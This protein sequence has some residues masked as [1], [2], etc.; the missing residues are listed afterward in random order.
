[1]IFSAEEQK[2]LRKCWDCAVV[3]CPAF[4][5]TTEP[6]SVAISPE[7]FDNERLR[8]WIHELMTEPMPCREDGQKNEEK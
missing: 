3:E 7:T 4:R 2:Q 8:Q 5:T 1:M 6:I